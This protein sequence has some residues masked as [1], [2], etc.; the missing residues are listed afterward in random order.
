MRCGDRPGRVDSVHD[1]H[2]QIHHHHVRLEPLGEPDRHR[3]VG[4]LRRPPPC[5]PS[6][7]IGGA[8]T[9]GVQGV[10]V[11][12]SNRDLSLS[13]AIRWWRCG[14]A[15]ASPSA[16]RG[17]QGLVAREDPGATA[18][19]LDPTAMR[20]GPPTH[21]DLAA[22]RGAVHHAAPAG[23]S[24]PLGASP[25]VV[26]VQLPHQAVGIPA[27]LDPANVLAFGRAGRRSWPPLPAI[28]VGRHLDRRWQRT[29][30]ESRRL[31]PG[32][33]VLLPYWAAS[34]R[35]ARC[36][37]EFVERRRPELV[38]QGLASATRCFQPLVSL[39]AAVQPPRRRVVLR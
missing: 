38:H 3:S 34:S 35:T 30:R 39:V 19:P 8:E 1:R 37:T 13:L 15:G 32:S 9:F 31:D 28:R 4:R 7:L 27:R 22:A 26:V 21:L 12:V 5:P 11:D 36:Q 16:R 14:W 24:V 10:V 23:L 20:S 33:W 17:S 18:V 25:A 6:P 2:V 29:E